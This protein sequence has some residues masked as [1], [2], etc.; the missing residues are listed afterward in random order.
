[1]P[2][3]CALLHT[4]GSVLLHS[5]VPILYAC[6]HG[7]KVL[8]ESVRSTA[9]KVHRLAMQVQCLADLDQNFVTVTHSTIVTVTHSTT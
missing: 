5:E 8:Y 2:R 3:N 4:A 6:L 9:C 7:L 1:M